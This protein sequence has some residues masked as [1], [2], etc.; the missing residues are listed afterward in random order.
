MMLSTV[1]VSA[2][3]MG[4]RRQSS[5]KKAQAPLSPFG[6]LD[7]QNAPMDH[8]APPITSTS[9][10]NFQQVSSNTTAKKYAILLKL[11]FV[12]PYA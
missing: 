6:D 4:I 7:Q 5:G 3:D 9:G 1:P 8:T 12:S 10:R 11:H 2:G